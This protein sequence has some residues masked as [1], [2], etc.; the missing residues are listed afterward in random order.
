[1]AL[2]KMRPGRGSAK[3]RMVSLGEKIASLNKKIA[4]EIS[5]PLPDSM[6]LQEL[7]RLRLK[8]KENIHALS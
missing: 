1:T 3:P 6:R 8:V 5:R 7:K 2:R 4:K